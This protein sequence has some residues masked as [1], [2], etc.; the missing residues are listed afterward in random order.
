[1]KWGDALSHNY[2]GHNSLSLSSTF[3]AFSSPS[4]KLFANVNV[5]SFSHAAL[6]FNQQGRNAGARGRHYPG[7]E[8]LWGRWNAAGKPKNPNNVTRTFFHTVHLLPEELRFKNGGAE[9]ASCPVCHLTSLIPCQSGDQFRQ[10]SHPLTFMLQ[11]FDADKL[12]TH[13]LHWQKPWNCFFV[14]IL[15]ACKILSQW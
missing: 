14:F 2:V 7:A 13:E 5:C 4:G 10:E 11:N 1:M 15:E 9:L 3:N 6:W 12:R 8:S